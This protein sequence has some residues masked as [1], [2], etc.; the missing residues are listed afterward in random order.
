[1]NRPPHISASDRQLFQLVSR[2]L[3]QILSATI[4][5]MLSEESPAPRVI[6]PLSRSAIFALQKVGARIAKYSAEAKPIFDS[7]AAKT[8]KLLQTAILFDVFTATSTI[9]RCS[10]S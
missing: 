2:P 3:R 5:W 6:G 7:T 4:D 1:M 8:R 9:C 10:T